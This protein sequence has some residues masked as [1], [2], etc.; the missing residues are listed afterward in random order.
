M[1]NFFT[2]TRTATAGLFLIAGVL[3]S[4]AFAQDEAERGARHAE[5]QQR[6]AEFLEN[7]PQVAA[8]MEERRR[9]REAFMADNPNAT[10]Q[11]RREHM[12]QRFENGEG[13][14]PQGGRRFNG[15]HQGPPGNGGDG[16]GPRQRPGTPEAD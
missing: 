4:P 11:A 14:G 3:S 12:R 1:K 8:R 2:V 7:N 9:E 10:P 6:R 15:R 5:M 13:R 16:R